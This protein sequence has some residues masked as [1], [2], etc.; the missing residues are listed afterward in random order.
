MCALCDSGTGS[1]RFEDTLNRINEPPWD[2]DVSRFHATPTKAVKTTRG[3][4][5]GIRPYSQSD[6][7][8]V[9]KLLSILPL[10]YPEGDLWLESRLQDASRGK[11]RCMIA[12][13]R[14]WGP[15]GIT[16]E[17]PKGPR[18]V[19]LSTI[20]VSPRF[21]ELG[22]GTAL[23]QR[24]REHW[25]SKKL[26]NVYVTADTNSASELLPLISR[27]GFKLIATEFNRYGPDRHEMVLSWVPNK[28]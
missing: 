18:K 25:R 16:I 7:G 19:K 6:H 10:L 5:F 2:K 14:R 26:R 13:T 17:T 27:Y 11:A 3:I 12:D 21:R 20:F 23:L 4:E 22:I 1:P 9:L 15:V 24:C 28:K 8:A